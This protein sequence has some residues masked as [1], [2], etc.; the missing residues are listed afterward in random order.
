MNFA[1]ATILVGMTYSYLPYRGSYLPN[2]LRVCFF[3]LIYFFVSSCFLCSTPD[4]KKMMNDDP[5]GQC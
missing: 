3:D 1:I 4:G 2:D 5:D